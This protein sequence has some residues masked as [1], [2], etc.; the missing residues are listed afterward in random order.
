[1]LCF[2]FR[3][4]KEK[5]IIAKQ[6]QKKKEKSSTTL[7]E[8]T[9]QREENYNKIPK[10]ALKRKLQNKKFFFLSQPSKND[11]VLGSSMNKIMRKT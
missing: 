4:F 6:E 8:V 2:I 11:F 9:T 5:R 7:N 3:K 1:M 10:L